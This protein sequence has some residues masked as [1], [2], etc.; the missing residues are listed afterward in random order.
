MELGKFQ[1]ANRPA[2][3]LV[4]SSK[5]HL[6]V[7]VAAHGLLRP[8]LVE[9]LGLTLLLRVTHDV[10]HCLRKVQQWKSYLT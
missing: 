3:A 10:R 4:R 2:Q 5:T 1:V 8:R 6:A 9:V 7:E